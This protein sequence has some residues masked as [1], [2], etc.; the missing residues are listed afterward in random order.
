MATN[1]VPN[2]TSLSQLILLL[3]NSM[4]PVQ[5][6]RETAM[7]ALETFQSQPE[8]LNYLCYILIEGASN[9]NIAS[10]FQPHEL[11]AFIKKYNASK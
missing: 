5:Q 6:D 1:W 7:D 10:Q 3:R 4:S 9:P 11:S 8:F 2:E